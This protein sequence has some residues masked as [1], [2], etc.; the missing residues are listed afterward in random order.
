MGAQSF[1]HLLTTFKEDEPEPPTF[2]EDEL[3]AIYEDLL[4]SPDAVKQHNPPSQPQILAPEE[5]SIV[6]AADQRLRLDTS[7]NRDMVPG[8]L[9]R[10]SPQS[11]GSSKPALVNEPSLPAYQRV[12]L[13]TEVVVGRLEDNRVSG[14]SPL[15]IAI[16][17]GPEWNAVVAIAV[18]GYLRTLKVA[19]LTSV[20]ASV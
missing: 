13:N 12:L 18:R 16:L 9:D 4:A 1:F 15:P 8:L 3:L 2:S 10:I 5:L 17:S 11:S 14:T 6:D 20:S 19:M 7:L